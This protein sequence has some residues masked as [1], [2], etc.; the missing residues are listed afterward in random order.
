[1]SA[2]QR[3]GGKCLRMLTQELSCKPTDL[4][5]MQHTSK[6]ITKILFEI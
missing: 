1:M 5:S 2:A 6:A 3:T 4:T